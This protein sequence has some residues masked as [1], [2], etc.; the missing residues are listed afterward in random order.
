M[1]SRPRPGTSACHGRPVG[2]R[3][4]ERREA[5]LDRGPLLLEPWRQDDP[6]PELLDRAVDGE[7]GLRRRELEQDPARLAE[8]D[9]A[10]V[11]AVDDPAVRD[12][13]LLQH[14]EPAPV[15][16]L[17][18]VPG[19]VVDRAGTLPRGL[20][21]DRVERDPAA[22]CVAAELPAV[23]VV[24]LGVH[25]ALEH[26]RG[27][28]W[29]VAVG[30]DALEAVQ[31]ELRRDL[32]MDGDERRIA[33]LVD[34]E[35]VL[36][37]LG[38][39]EQE[40]ALTSLD[41][42]ALR[43]E[44]VEPEAERLRRA[45]PPDDTV[46]RP[47]AGFARQRPGVLEEREVGAGASDL[48]AVEQVVHA[49]VVLVHRLRGQPQPEHAR[50]EVDVPRGVARDRG[51]VVD[52]VESH[53]VSFLS[54]SL[55]EQ[56]YSEVVAL[57][58]FSEARQPACFR[59]AAC[60]PEARRRSSGVSGKTA[61]GSP[62]AAQISSNASRSSSTYIGIGR[63]C[64]KGG[65]PPI[66]KPVCS[67]VARASAL[68][69]F[70]RPAAAAPLAGSNRL[71]PETRK[72]TGSPSPSTNTSVF[73][74]CASEQPIARAASSAVCVPSGKRRART[75]T[76]ARAPAST[77]RWTRGSCRSAAM[78]RSYVG[79]GGAV[80]AARPALRGRAAYPPRPSPSSEKTRRAC[81]RAAAASFGPLSPAATRS[82][83]NATSARCPPMS[84][85]AAPSGSGS[86]GRAPVS[87]AIT[88]ASSAVYR[89]TISR[90]RARSPSLAGIVE[91]AAAIT[92]AR[93][94]SARRG[95]PSNTTFRK[96]AS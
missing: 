69:S 58:S 44:S 9:R 73:T 42:D 37:A 63:S 14:V 23:A 36:K 3:V 95:I 29:P 56:L 8:V 12:A 21:R 15:L 52:A 54:K 53:L 90:S 71:A 46:H 2:P 66:E 6:R 51:D 24:R 78:S 45:D 41:G 17:G 80:L 30:A 77:T 74:I 60:A 22:A 48:V 86:C 47:G 70:A 16:G 19:D 67:F 25:Q 32:R 79:A 28:L 26:R 85:A 82:W 20:V 92:P 88:S 31:R 72:A 7:P 38:V 91:R 59:S 43:L 62:A 93:D 13:G 33:A 94:G 35:L 75:S 64:P 27:R 18:R 83:T 39:G 49:R 55:L 61:S 68:R 76:P 4:G 96:A 5:R 40:R 10:E 34:D 81:A 11:V 65:M 84:A 89:A 50:V 57:S 87:A 1:R